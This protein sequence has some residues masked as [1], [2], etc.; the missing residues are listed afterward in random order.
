MSFH[1]DGRWILQMTDKTQSK[2][3]SFNKYILK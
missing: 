3:E 2:Y 1:L